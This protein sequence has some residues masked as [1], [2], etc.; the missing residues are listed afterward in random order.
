MASEKT[1]DWRPRATRKG[2]VIEEAG[3]ELLVYNLRRHHAHC[4]NNTAVRIWRLCT[5]RLTVPQIAS[6][7]KLSIDPVSSGTVVLDTIIQFDHL[8]LVEPM[9]GTVPDMSRRQMVRRIGAAAAA[10][11]TLPLITSIVAPTPAHAA[12]CGSAGALCG[13]GHPPCCPGL[14]CQNQNG[15]LICQG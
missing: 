14:S 8:G 9:G 3:D 10:G 7:L 11:I 13:A 1:Q 15:T 2:W 5:G 6:A 12:S 4:L